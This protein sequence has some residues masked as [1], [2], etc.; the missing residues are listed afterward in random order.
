MFLQSESLRVEAICCLTRA[1]AKV[2]NFK[3]APIE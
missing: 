3:K 2:L 1:K